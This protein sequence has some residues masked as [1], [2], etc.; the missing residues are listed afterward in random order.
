LDEVSIAEPNEEFI[1]TGDARIAYR[2]DDSDSGG[3]AI[4]LFV[5]E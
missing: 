1:V 2:S 3:G 4:A 5:G